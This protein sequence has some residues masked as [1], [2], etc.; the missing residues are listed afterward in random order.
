LR[1]IFVLDLFQPAR[2]D[3]RQATSLVEREPSR[4][5]RFL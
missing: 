4:E 1:E 2:P 3:L 5:T